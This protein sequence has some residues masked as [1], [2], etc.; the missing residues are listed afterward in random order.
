MRRLVLTMW[1]R[2]ILFLVGLGVACPVLANYEQGRQLF[3]ARDY[4]G[5]AAA[6]FNS[7]SAPRSKAERAKAEYA[8]ALSLQ[9]LGLYYSASK[10][11]SLIIRRGNAPSNPFFKSALDEMGK[12]NS[13]I[14]IGQA[15]I[16][17]LFKAKV[18]SSDVPGAARGFYFYYL[19]VESFS[20]RRLEQAADHFEKVPSDSPYYLGAMFHLG[21]IS[22]LSGKHSKAIAI[23][24]KVL[25]ETRDRERYQEIYEQ[26]LLNIARVNY[27]T[28]KYIPSLGYYKEIPRDSD[29]WLDAIWETSWAFFF[30]EKFNNTLG[31]IH[32]IHSPFFINR[33]YPESYILQAI[34]FLRLCRFDQVKESMRRF[35]TRYAPVFGDV[36][37]L[38]SKYERDPR[39][40]FKVVYDY[41]QGDLRSYKNAE[42]IIKKLSLMDAF[43]EARDTIRFSDRELDALGRYRGKWSSSGLL[44]SLTQFLKAKKSA[45]VA[46]SGARLYKLATTYYSQLIDLS[47]Q[48]KFI[49]AEM[50]LGKID[51]LRAKLNINTKKDKT[52]FIGGLQPLNLSQ[53]LE[54]WPFEK[55]YW[56]DE[57]GYYVYNMDS[58]C[59]VAKGK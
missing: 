19:G 41:R 8:L 26:T 12:M 6:Y 46:D 59:V 55:E 29:N 17:Q 39:G 1:L 35:K 50:Q 45:A 20:K 36:K 21:V 34:T 24:E 28:K 7:Y 51:T 2:L 31:N 57:L 40:F 11:F 53:G 27:E 42:E 15:Q 13:N 22:N 48:T 54:Y 37:S 16:V 23:F 56:E 32:T 30:M 47:N 4:V 49:V 14:S 18:R 58:K 5:A 38:L 44:D 43:K 9:R 52:E 33:F 10:Y 25:N 3:A